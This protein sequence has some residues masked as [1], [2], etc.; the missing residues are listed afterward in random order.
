VCT[1]MIL[2][3]KLYVPLAGAVGGR[4]VLTAE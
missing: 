1:M 2:P 4:T 3:G